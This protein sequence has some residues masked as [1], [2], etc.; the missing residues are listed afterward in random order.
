MS[1]RQNIFR[2]YAKHVWGCEVRISSGATRR[3][4]SWGIKNSSWWS[5][6]SCSRRYRV[7]GYV[8]TWSLRFLWDPP[9]V[10]F[11]IDTY[12]FPVS[13]VDLDETLSE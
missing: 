1:C 13:S 8:K 12:G 5:G 4:G 6:V 3:Q 2:C 7:G 11:G 9:G 10:S